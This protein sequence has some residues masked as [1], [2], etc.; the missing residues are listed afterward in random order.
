[1]D[2]PALAELISIPGILSGGGFEEDLFGPWCANV[3]HR[4]VRRAVSE[5][6]VYINETCISTPLF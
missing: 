5:E 4:A 3:V 6:Y 2:D 1:M